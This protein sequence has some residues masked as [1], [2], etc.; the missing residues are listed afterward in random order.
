M[1]AGKNATA[2]FGIDEN[3]ALIFYGQYNS[4]MVAGTGG[5]TILKTD[6]AAFS[7]VSNKPVIE[8]I[9]VSYL[10]TGDTY[11]FITGTVKPSPGKAQV[12]GAEHYKTYYWGRFGLL[13]SGEPS[14]RECMTRHLIDN[15]ANDSVQNITPISIQEG[16]QLT[17]RKNPESQGFFEDRPGFPEKYTVT[18]IMM[19]LV[20]VQI[21]VKPIK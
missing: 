20:P 16:Y 8:N 19:D 7:F 14:I 6:G 11:D 2:G 18:G 21:S 10:E 13:S 4:M 15:K 5:V 17:L 3:T 9:N 12:R 1:D